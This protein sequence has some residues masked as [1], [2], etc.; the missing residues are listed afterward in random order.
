MP[1]AQGNL[2]GLKPSQ[3]KALERLYKRRLPAGEVYA[4]EQARELAMLSRSMNRQI[5]MLINRQGKVELVLAG[6]AT[7]ISIPELATLAGGRLRGVRLLHTHL[8]PEGL[9]RE[10]L[11]DMLFLRLDAITSLGVS[12]EGEPVQWQA[13]F[14]M[15]PEA[16][17]SLLAVPVEAC[18]NSCYVAR[19]RAWHDTACDFTQLARDIEG[20]LGSSVEEARS[21]ENAFLI[22]VSPEPLPLQER[23]LQELE[24]LALSAGLNVAGKMVQRVMRPNPRLILGKGKLLELEVQALNARADILIFDGELTPAQLGNL[25]ELTERKV[26]DR[27]QLILDIF[28]Q[29]AVTRAGRLQV[30]LAQLAYGQPRLAGKGKALDR[31][32]GGIGGRGPGESKL[33]TDRRKSRERMAILRRELERLQRQRGLERQRRERNAV[34]VAALVGYTNAG[35]S[36]LLNKLTDSEVLSENKLFATLDPITRRLR[37]PREREITLADTVGF[38]RNLPRELMEAF[39]ATL[40]ELRRAD[41]LI[42]VSDASHPELENQMAAVEN[43]LEELELNDLP[44]ILVLN[45]WDKINPEL[46]EALM[47][48]WPEALP[49]SALDGSGLAGLLLR[50]EQELFL[51]KLGGSLDGVRA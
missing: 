43:I 26:M 3:L 41:A 14:V 42:H 45:K 13:A 40:E 2:Q 23:N 31:L 5:A 29:H 50:L 15:P 34:P 9:S 24:D 33:E 39:R 46:R 47:A 25:A 32:A 21:G 11:M 28:A 22:S 30:E 48:R 16:P 4:P 37:F 44:Q 10:D 8:T 51:K 18:Q 36:S 27:T 12:P 49:V 17:Q 19:P 38:I 35:K 1:A 7:G 20:R 6:T